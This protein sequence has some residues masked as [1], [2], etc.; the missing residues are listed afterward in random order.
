MGVEIPTL[1]VGIEAEIAKVTIPLVAGG[2][3]DRISDGLPHVEI[4]CQIM[5]L[6][7]S[8]LLHHFGGY[9]VQ[10]LRNPRNKSG[11]V[12]IRI[13]S[14]K[15]HLEN[16]R[17]G[18]H[19]NFECDNTF[20]GNG[21]LARPGTQNKLTTVTI[22][23]IDTFGTLT[24]FDTS[25]VVGAVPETHWEEGWLKD[26]LGLQIRV[27]SWTSN[28]PLRF[29]LA[30]FPPPTW[31]S[32]KVLTLVAGCNRTLTKCRFWNNEAGFAGLMVDS[33]AYNPYWE[34]P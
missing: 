11:L 1:T 17:M 4:N 6:T 33:P 25:G 29:L 23:S 22:D 12:E 3:S 27:K 10:T 30:D 32:G 18:R 16:R 15:I 7:T 24:I 2:F 13:G 31:K 21:C 26:E 20:M 28:S 8:Q 19:A 34:A 14:P 5:E 9:V